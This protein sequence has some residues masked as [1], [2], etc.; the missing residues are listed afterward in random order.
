VSIQQFPQQTVS[1][2][3]SA[4]PLLLILYIDSMGL[5][6]VFPILN[7]LLFAEDGLFAHSFTSSFAS[8]SLYAVMIA[9]FMLCWFFGAAILGDLSDQIG[10]KKSLMI[11]L[12]GAFLGYLFSALAILG[13]SLTLLFL[14]RVI[15]GLTAGSQPIAQAA[16]VDLSAPHERTRNFSYMLLVFSL[17]FIS[18]PLLGGVL[19]NRDLVS[20]F[21]PMVPFCFVAL[22]A[23]V[24]IVF[25]QIG[26]QE[27][28]VSKG[29]I[30]INFMYPF[31]IFKA[32]FS[33]SKVCRLSIVF[34]LF[35][36]GWSSFYSFIS[37]FAL[38]QLHF[39]G[40][41]VNWLM[42]LMGAGFGLGNGFLVDYSSKRMRLIRLFQYYSLATALS[43]LLV[44]VFHQPILTWVMTFFIGAVATV[45]YAG[46]LSLYSNQVD[47]SRQGW[48]MGIN[49]AVMSFVFGVN[50][51]F[52]GMLSTISAFIPMW[53]AV[54]GL[55]IC[56]G[57]PL[58]GRIHET[59]Q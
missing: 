17:G 5:G 59:P 52:I 37:L 27:T 45:A 21:T 12:V 47:Q 23:L 15:A 14:G 31:F 22:T 7:A 35:I 29:P 18:G 40:K 53:C 56:L 49:G 50:A 11:C 34:S 54:L 57:I 8:H 4:F 55:I 51:L 24:N 6:L 1:F 19:S 32:A 42:A 58:I 36:F 39:V 46:I 30:K 25:L 9:T 38:E 44:L 43:I 20:W 10:R 41:Q 13:H 28:F 3:K 16:I 48:V 2:F 33:E 26:F